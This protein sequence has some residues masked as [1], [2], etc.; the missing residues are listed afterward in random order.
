MNMIVEYEM[1]RRYT[2]DDV[3]KHILHFNFCSH[4]LITPNRYIQCK[5]NCLI[6]LCKKIVFIYISNLIIIK[7]AT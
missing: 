6:A 3:Q 5:Q 7:K 4:K 2:M 1:K